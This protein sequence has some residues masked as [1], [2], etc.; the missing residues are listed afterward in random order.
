MAVAA[1]SLTVGFER[2]DPIPDLGSIT[3]AAHAL[4]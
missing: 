1:A 2:G 3:E 4:L